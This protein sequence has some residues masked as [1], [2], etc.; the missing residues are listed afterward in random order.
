MLDDNAAHAA[1]DGQGQPAEAVDLHLH[2]LDQLPDAGM[3]GDYRSYDL[4]QRASDVSPR[5]LVT[6][7]LTP[8]SEFAARHRLAQAPLDEV[9]PTLN[10]DF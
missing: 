2:L 3:V 9:M 8:A 4:F 10:R 6:I 5:Q 1:G 7:L